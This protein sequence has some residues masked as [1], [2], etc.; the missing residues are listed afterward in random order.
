MIFNNLTLNMLDE[1]FSVK[2]IKKII[3]SYILFIIFIRFIIFNN[4]DN[5]SILFNIIVFPTWFFIMGIFAYNELKSKF[6]ISDTL[7]Y[8]DAFSW[9]KIFKLYENDI[10]LMRF[11]KN[12]K[13]MAW[14]VLALMFS[15]PFLALLTQTNWKEVLQTL[16]A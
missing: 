8:Q 1:N 11:K 12:T 13:K 16:F 6:Y 7:D 2:P 14:F 15:F 9:R 3:I 4:L 10:I 5:Y